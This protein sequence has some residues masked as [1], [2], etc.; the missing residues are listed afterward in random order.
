M[1]LAIDVGNTETV[2]GLYALTAAEGEA[3]PPSD[4]G[5][6]ASGPRTSPRRG[7]THHWRLSTVPDRTPDEYAVLLTQLLDLEGLDIAA[8]VDGHRHQLLGAAVTGELRQMAARW[9]AERA[10]ASSSAPG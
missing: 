9:F 3:L 4:A 5:R 8:T 6:S 7:L 10:R 1:L 2:V